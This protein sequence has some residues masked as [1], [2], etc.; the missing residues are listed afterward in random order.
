MFNYFQFINE[1]RGSAWYLFLLH[2]FFGNPWLITKYTDSGIFTFGIVFWK[3]SW[4]SNFHKLEIDM[5]VDSPQKTIQHSRVMMATSLA[6]FLKQ[7]FLLFSTWAISNIPRAHDRAIL[8]SHHLFSQWCCLITHTELKAMNWE[9]SQPLAMQHWERRFLYAH[10]FLHPPFPLGK[11]TIKSPKWFR[12]SCILDLV[13][14][15]SVRN[16][17]LLSILQILISK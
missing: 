10:S 9:Y 16:C 11:V 5:C 6:T 4:L 13:G 12:Y 8:V 14:I 3:K 15:S 2:I 17:T 1:L 7:C